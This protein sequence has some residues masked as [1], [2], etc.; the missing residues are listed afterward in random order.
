MKPSD[1]YFSALMAARAA[2]PTATRELILRR[3]FECEKWA[4]A[5]ASEARPGAMREAMDAASRDELVRAYD[6]LA[7]IAC[8]ALAAEKREA[9][10]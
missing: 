10:S 8:D 3:E 4:R 5:G 2:L 7:Q 6:R 9:Q 1:L